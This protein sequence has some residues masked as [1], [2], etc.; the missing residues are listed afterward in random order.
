MNDQSSTTA[1]LRK[2]ADLADRNGHYDAADWLRNNLRARPLKFYKH[3]ALGIVGTRT[4]HE[5]GE[6]TLLQ[7]H[8]LK[9]SWIRTADLH[10]TREAAEAGAVATFAEMTTL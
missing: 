2:V 7:G 8:T 3:E 5:D 4:H 6:Y 1:Q 10:D 9:Y